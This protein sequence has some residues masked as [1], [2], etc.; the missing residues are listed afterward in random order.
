MT[1]NVYAINYQCKV[2]VFV[3]NKGVSNGPS[4]GVTPFACAKAAPPKLGR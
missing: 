3:P 2:K 4:I 1:I